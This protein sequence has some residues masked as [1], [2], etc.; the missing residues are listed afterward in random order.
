MNT[1][2]VKDEYK[3]KTFDELKRVYDNRCVTCGSLENKPHFHDASKKTLLQ[4]GH[5]DPLKILTIEN[6]IPQCQFC[7]QTYKDNFIFKCVKY[8]L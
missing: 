5:M 4:Q 1:F 6:T 2:N 7:N 3:D 8:D